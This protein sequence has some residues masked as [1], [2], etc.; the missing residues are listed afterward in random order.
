MAIEGRTRKPREPRL[1]LRLVR[2]SGEAFSEGVETHVIEGVNVRVFTLA[3]TIAD[4][5]KY[6][7]KLGLDVALEA[8]RD[9]RR[10]RCGTMNE[11]VALCP[12]QPGVERRTL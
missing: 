2:F 9:T 11:P 4:C 5:F 12:H 8:L 3:K 6:R 1:P 10:P 7:H